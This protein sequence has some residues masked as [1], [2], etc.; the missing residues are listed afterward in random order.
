[1]DVVNLE[2]YHFLARF[3]LNFNKFPFLTSAEYIGEL[4]AY[5]TF[6]TKSLSAKGVSRL[7]WKKIFS[8]K[9]KVSRR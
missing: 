7:Y 2:L 5:L 8:L 6:G 9:V 1:M 4:I 3:L